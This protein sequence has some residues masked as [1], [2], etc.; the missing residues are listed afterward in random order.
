MMLLTTQ[1]IANFRSQLSEHEEIMEALDLIED[2]EGDIED[3][4]I[5]LAL[6]AGMEPN[7]SEN[8]LESEAKRCR[9]AIC[10]AE[11]REDLVKGNLKKVVEYL[12]EKK[13]CP[14]VLAAPVVIYALKTGVE[15]FCKPLD[16]KL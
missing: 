8:W 15:E 4:A 2:C 10:E 7:T 16:Y 3:A 1:E 5:S 11:F 12:I 13:V 9:V 14:P 6:K